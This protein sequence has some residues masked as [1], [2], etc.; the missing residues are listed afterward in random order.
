MRKETIF[1]GDL[2]DYLR[3]EIYR[4]FG[5]HTACFVYRDDE[6][7]VRQCGSG[8]FVK[9][10]QHFG[11]L[12]AAHVVRALKEL[13]R[14]GSKWDFAVP[15]RRYAISPSEV[16]Y[17]TTHDPRD[18]SLGPDLGFVRFLSADTVA[19]VGSVVTFV[20]LEFQKSRVTKANR[21]RGGFWVAVGYPDE[22]GSRARNITRVRCTS[23]VGGRE[24]RTVR[25]N[26]DYYDAEVRDR[27][28]MPISF[29]GLSGGGFW[30]FSLS[31][32]AGAQR[33]RVA[34][35][36]FSGVVFY[37]RKRKNDGVVLAIRSHGRKSIY[38]YAIDEL[39][40]GWNKSA[41]TEAGA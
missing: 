20:D 35:R 10:R 13:A 22:F 39:I 8:T 40:M 12:T 38:D 2:P 29:K 19:S 30:L 15:Y 14:Q 3:E 6:N 23:F 31:K 25:G 7:Q 37:E 34:E 18:E 4:G 24:S 21:T 41:G 9:Y 16:D 28:E 36:F 32:K 26:F 5:N 33:I 11:I 27:D 1:A 17:T